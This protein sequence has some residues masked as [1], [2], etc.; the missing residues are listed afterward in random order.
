[1]I[2]DLGFPYPHADLLEFASLSE[3][4]EGL[5]VAG[6]VFP[7][8]GRRGHGM[9]QLVGCFPSN[10]EGVPLAICQSAPIRRCVLSSLIFYR[11][12]ISM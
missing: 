5:G 12:K 2:S 4:L 10:A 8:G 3:A 11:I 9:N 1:M 7:Y 6:A